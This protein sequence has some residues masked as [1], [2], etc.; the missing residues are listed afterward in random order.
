MARDRSDVISVC[1]MKNYVGNVVSDTDGM[2]DVCIASL[3][4]SPLVCKNDSGII[5]D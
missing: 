4:N 2:K 5:P 3:E 1:C